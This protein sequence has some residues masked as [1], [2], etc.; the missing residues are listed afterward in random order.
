MF[1]IKS[2]VTELWIWGQFKRRS[3]KK[4]YVVVAAWIEE[5]GLDQC[6]ILVPSSAVISGIALGTSMSPASDSLLVI[7]LM[8]HEV[9]VLYQAYI[10]CLG[11]R[12]KHVIL[13]NVWL[14]GSQMCSL[15]CFSFHMYFFC[16]LLIF[17]FFWPPFQ[18]AGRINIPFSL[19]S[20]WTIF[21]KAKK[22]WIIIAFSLIHSALS[23]GRL[24]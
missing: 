7:C 2:K 10:T 17:L 21:L 9:Y 1:M 22:L 24:K 12:G 3:G 6:Y 14:N 8:Y 18:G 23:D 4:L 13:N 19:A 20:F 11:H 5:E 15:T 16:L